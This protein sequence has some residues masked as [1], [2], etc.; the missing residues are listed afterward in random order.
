METPSTLERPTAVMDAAWCPRRPAGVTLSG[1]SVVE[2]LL[3]ILGRRCR[4]PSRACSVGT[5]ALLARTT[6]SHA[7]LVIDLQLPPMVHLLDGSG[8][9]AAASGTM[10]R[11]FDGDCRPVT[12]L[13]QDQMVVRAPETSAHRRPAWAPSLRGSQDR[14][15]G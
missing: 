10:R 8:G 5:G 14:S 6:P 1:K 3:Y 9:L 11:D 13:L 7:F 12:V 2:P 4:K 15:L